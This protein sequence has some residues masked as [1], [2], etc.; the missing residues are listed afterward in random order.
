MSDTSLP[1]AL[2]GLIEHDDV[3]AIISGQK[4]MLS[5][6]EKTNE[7]LRSCN[8][9][10]EKQQ[11]TLTKNLQSHTVVLTEL[12]TDLQSIFTRIRKLKRQLNERET[13]SSSK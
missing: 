13:D 4:C 1:E 9:I 3:K 2:D 7:V 6:L 5:E 12:K 10:A 11:A 8:E